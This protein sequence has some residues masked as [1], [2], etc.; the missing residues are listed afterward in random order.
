MHPRPPLD[1]LGGQAP[2]VNPDVLPGSLQRRIG[3][4]RPRYAGL[5]QPGFGLQRPALPRPALLWGVGVVAP[6]P[7]R[8]RT[9]QPVVAPLADKQVRVRVAASA[10]VDRQGV[11]E[12]LGVGQMVGKGDGQVP[13]LGGGQR[14]GQRDFHPLEQPPVGPLVQVRRIPVGPRI[15]F[16][17]AWHVPGFGVDQLGLSSP[18]VLS[19]ALDVGGRGPGRLAGAPRPV[20]GVQVVDGTPTPSASGQAAPVRGVEAGE[21]LGLG[22][23]GRPAARG[24]GKRGGRATARTRTAFLGE[25]R[26]CAPS[27]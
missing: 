23:H 13:L 9:L 15:A 16:R 20:A 1:A 22:I 4:L 17:P 12:P 24:E 26:L 7:L 8:R 18:A 3:L 19:R 21:T 2:V 14:Q 10:G 5:R 27:L 25:K 6:K 11:G